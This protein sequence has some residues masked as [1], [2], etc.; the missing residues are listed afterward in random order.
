MEQNIKIQ[1]HNLAIRSIISLHQPL[2]SFLCVFLPNDLI[3]K[4]NK[5]ECNVLKIHSA[6]IEL[7]DEECRPVKIDK[8]DKFSIPP[9]FIALWF[10]L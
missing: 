8:T 1:E 2:D 3:I 5:I 6:D 4:F 7:V 10:N 9:Y